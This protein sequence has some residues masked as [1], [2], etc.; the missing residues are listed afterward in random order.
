[1]S[2]SPA[3]GPEGGVGADS[4]NKTD[5]EPHGEAG[6]KKAMEEA[7][8]DAAEERANEGGYQ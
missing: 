7:Q 5:T 8:E 3:S 4:H 2:Q 6:K 1:M